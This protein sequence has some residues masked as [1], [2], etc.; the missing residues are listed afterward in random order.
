MKRLD[1]TKVSTKDLQ[2]LEKK[3][4][5]ELLKRKTQQTAMVWSESLN[6][7]NSGKEEKKEEEQRAEYYIG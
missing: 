7:V 3:I 6:N 4:N 5:D 2:E 1:V